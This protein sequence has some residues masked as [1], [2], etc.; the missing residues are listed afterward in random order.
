MA[1]GSRERWVRGFGEIVIIF[2]G[3]TLGLL[4]EDWRQGREDESV[5]VAILVQLAGDLRTDSVQT[6]RLRTSA[7]LG[8]RRGL[9]L[10]KALARSDPP[11]DSVLIGALGLIPGPVYR[12]AAT[13]YANLKEGGHLA[14]VPDT[15]LRSAISRYYEQDQSLA[16]RLSEDLQGYQLEFRRAVGRH[17]R[18]GVEDSTATMI[19]PP[20]FAWTTSVDAVAADRGVLMLVE[21]LTIASAELNVRLS[22]ILERNA[23]LRA[24]LLQFREG[25]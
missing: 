1:T 13:A 10:L 4:A 6:V 2:L 24:Q 25:R 19:P 18:L 15:A 20:P 9:E 8:H 12:P 23:D 21:D 17:M 16:R 7:D 22:S 5:A 11:A 14:L 3:V